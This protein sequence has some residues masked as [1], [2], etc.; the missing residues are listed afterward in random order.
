MT[1]NRQWAPAMALL[2]ADPMTAFPRNSGFRIPT[3]NNVG[4]VIAS[5]SRSKIGPC[6][7]VIMCT[8][9]GLFW[10]TSGAQ[11]LA[12][13]TASL[14]SKDPGEEWLEGLLREF[15]GQIFVPLASAF[16][17]IHFS[18]IYRMRMLICSRLMKYPGQYDAEPI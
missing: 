13:G 1:R 17:L 4:A 12:C 3:Q 8:D 14:I 7:S 10:C 6:L 2:E 9:T 18:S 11:R 16:S 15:H 5:P